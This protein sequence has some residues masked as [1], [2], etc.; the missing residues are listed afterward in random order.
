[1]PIRYLLPRFMILA[2]L[3]AAPPASAADWQKVG[4]SSRLDL[5]VDRGSITREGSRV[6]ALIRTE[7]AQPQA[8][9]RMT[10][11]SSATRQAAPHR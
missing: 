8:G 3:A 2:T 6:A 1:M 5:Y 7:W 11:R 4:G 10:Y 9:A